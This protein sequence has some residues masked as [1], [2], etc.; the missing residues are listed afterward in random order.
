MRTMMRTDSG[1]TTSVWMATA[2]EPAAQPLAGA[3]QGQQGNELTGDLTCDVVIVGAGIAGLSVG[4]HLAKA[5]KQVV[6]LDDG[7][8]AGGETCRTTAHLTSVIDDRFFEMERLHGEA[9]A[10]LAYDS[11]QRAIERIAEIVATENIDCDFQ[12]V[13]GFLFLHE[14]DTRE[15]LEKE[16][17][18]A[19]RVGFHDVEWW[20]PAL[21]AEGRGVPG[22]PENIALRFPRQGQFHILRYLNGLARAIV[23]NGGKI[24]RGVHANKITGGEKATVEV[25]SGQTITAGAVV[26]A[27]NT[28]VNDR[29]EIHTKQMPYRTYVVAA[30]VPRGTVVGVNGQRALYWDTGDP[31]HYVRLQESGDA[32]YEYLIVGGEDHKTGQA[33]DF[34]ERFAR[35]EAW[36][37]ERWPQ[38]S[39]FEFRWSGQ[40][41]ETDD[42][43]GFIG[44]N[45]MDARNVYIATGDSG[46]GMTHGTIAGMLIC[47]L[48]LDRYNPWEKLYDPRRIRLAAGGEYVKENLNTAAQY[49]EYFTGG[50]VGDENEIAAGQGAIV[51]H[52]LTKVAVYRDEAGALHRCSSVCP[53]LGGIVQWNAVEKT[54][55]CPAH[56][57]R[58]SVEDGHVV[59]GPAN[60]GLKRLEEP[61][62]EKAA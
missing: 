15:T 19:K 61:A 24:F 57:S 3:T 20:Q 40:V 11:H 28:P 55:D 2:D 13:D 62:E 25:G 10:K 54:W 32:N 59:N 53:H 52:G 5:G 58:F 60:S 36:T 14:G 43:L 12:R 17:A 45:P 42:G 22:S 44:H 50:D 41:M 9:G 38:A 35:L 56:G 21:N 29:V 33:Q 7:P 39:R 49:R 31:Y 30:R 27:T 47:D 18:A 1:N 51:R 46:M 8:V 4:Y 23:A 48:I 6:I 34:E 26:V 16:F 37:R